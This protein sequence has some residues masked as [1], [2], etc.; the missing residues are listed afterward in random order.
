LL[1]KLGSKPQKEDNHTINIKE[2]YKSDT[3]TQGKLNEFTLN[4]EHS[5][6]NN[7]VSKVSN[8][9]NSNNYNLNKD[10]ASPES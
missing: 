6:L 2:D 10:L 1:N 8:Q 4:K 5:K 9:D 3:N 7:D